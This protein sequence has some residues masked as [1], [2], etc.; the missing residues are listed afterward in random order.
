MGWLGSGVPAVTGARWSAGALW[1]ENGNAQASDSDWE[2]PADWPRT[3]PGTA[4][5]LAL[6]VF[7]AGVD[8]T[9]HTRAASWAHGQDDPIPSGLTPSSCS[10]T[11]DSSA[12]AVNIA[13][14]VVILTEYDSLWVGRAEDVATDEDPA[15]TVVAVSAVDDLSRGAVDSIDVTIDGQLVISVSG[16]GGPILRSLMRLAQVPFVLEDDTIG[17]AN[18]G[19][20]EPATVQSGSPLALLGAV[21]YHNGIMGSYT[22]AGLR[23]REWGRFVDSAADVILDD[24]RDLARTW[25]SGK[26]IS[27]VVNTLT[28]Q[29]DTAIDPAL[30]YTPD[31]TSVERY[32]RRPKD[33]ADHESWPRSEWTRS[34]RPWVYTDDFTEP[35]E[36]VKAGYLV[37]DTGDL[38]CRV[39]PLDRARQDSDDYLVMRVAHNLTVDTWTVDVGMIEARAVTDYD[40]YLGV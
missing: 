33:V 21:L 15:E 30:P 29:H 12:P 20:Y 22:P 34:I 31:P 7:I 4:E 5:A 23:F 11:L 9:E 2:D 16:Y 8:V 32:G 37:K 6:G 26:R 17:S 25:H 28:G 18:L 40:D 14:R 36:R 10:L 1:A 39:I 3:Y 19:Y 13:D 27:D 24:A 35:Y 38:A